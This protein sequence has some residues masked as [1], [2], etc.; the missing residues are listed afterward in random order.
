MWTNSMDTQQQKKYNI[1]V[2]GDNCV[3]IYQ[4]G[5]VERLSPEGP[6]PVFLYKY[7]VNKPGMAANVVENLE[8]LGC[9][10]NFLHG[11]TSVK[12]RLI[13]IKSKQHI[14]RI[15]NDNH[16]EP[17]TLETAIPD[18]YDAVVISD[19]NKGTVSYELME[20][21]IRDFKGP[22]FIDTK[23]RDLRRLEGAYVKINALEY[24][25][26]ES[27]CSELII[28]RGGDSVR[29]KVK[30][31]K[32]PEVEVVDVC[33]AGDTFLAAMAVEFLNT[34]DMIKSIE[35]AI[36]ASARTVQHT[37]VYSLT[38][39]DINEIRRIR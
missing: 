23:K 21:I 10:V 8:A 25:L 6:V 34:Q 29:Y 24:S 2:I 18:I 35:F 7:E 20:E 13:D 30:Q 36:E 11:A 4:Y 27:Q 3:D 19:Y 26:I 39:E 1:L 14:V 28:T 32:V 5:A 38:K 37:G 22:V 17:I 12:T 9:S 31:Y 15:D 16:S 33:G